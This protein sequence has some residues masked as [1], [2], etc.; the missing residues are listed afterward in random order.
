M[1]FELVS[2]N[3]LYAK[4]PDPQNHDGPD[5][6]RWRGGRARDALTLTSQ[7]RAGLKGWLRRRWDQKKG[8]VEAPTDPG[9]REAARRKRAK[10][11]R[12]LSRGARGEAGRGRRG[13]ARPRARAGPGRVRTAKSPVGDKR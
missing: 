6:T 3:F 10:R 13:D 7:A 5:D 8:P 11:P 12:G 4:S 2:R 1:G 9:P